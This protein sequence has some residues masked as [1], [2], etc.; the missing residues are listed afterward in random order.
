ML[1]AGVPESAFRWIGCGWLTVD[2]EPFQAGQSDY[3]QCSAWGARAVPLFESGAQLASLPGTAGQPSALPPARQSVARL[4][5]AAAAG[6]LGGRTVMLDLESWTFTPPGEQAGIDRVIGR[7]VR[8]SRT[9]GFRLVLTLGGRF[10]RSAAAIATVARDKAYGIALQSQGARSAAGWSAFVRGAIAA[11]RKRS[12]HMLIIAGL[13]TNTPQVHPVRLLE[14]QHA[15]GVADGT[16][17]FWLNASNWLD[18]NQ[19]GASQ[20]GPGCPRT[21]YQLFR[22]LR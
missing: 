20:G 7:A 5:A 1:A 6:A 10:A 3:T 19:C 8:L 15:I 9:D 12:P 13:A 21:G 18:K 22:G 11:V 14:S 17:A 4:A 2:G 16:T